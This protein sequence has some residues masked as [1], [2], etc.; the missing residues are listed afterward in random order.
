MSKVKF[1]FNTKSLI[2]EKVELSIKEKTLKV[3]SFLATGIVF[4]TITIILAYT[5]LDSP[6]EKRYVREIENLQLQYEILNNRLG[7]MS[8]VLEEMAARD[9]NIYRVIFEA[10]PIPSEV[11]DA[12]FGGSDR[13]EKLSGFDNTD[14]IMASSEKLDRIAKKMVVQSKS[15]DDVVKMAKNKSLMMASIPAIQPISNK[16]L[17]RIASGFNYRIHPIYKIM[18]FHPGLDFTSPVGTEVY[19]TG[20]GIVIACDSETRGYGNHIIVDHGYG[21]QTLYAHLSKFGVKTGQKVK[22]GE[23]IG[24]V[25]STGTSTAPHLHYEVIKNNQKVNPINYFYNDLSPAQFQ[26]VIELSSKANQSFD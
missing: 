20:D 7:H 8:A 22:R 1:R 24:F 3:L 13:Y 17:A 25:G 18:H 2:Y 26:K 5:Y 4:A 21:Y 23:R 10:E 19:S 11:R 9:D 15:F 16:N 12:G 14:L 6:K